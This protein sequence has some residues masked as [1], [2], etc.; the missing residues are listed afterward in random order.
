MQAIKN[1]ARECMSHETDENFR[2]RAL[3]EKLNYLL[4]ST[5]IVIYMHKIYDYEGMKLWTLTEVHSLQS[6]ENRSYVAVIKEL[7]I[8]DASAQN[9]L[10]AFSFATVIIILHLIRLIF[11]RRNQKNV[12]EKLCKVL[13]TTAISSKCNCM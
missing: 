8:K 13:T 11:C 3:I 9:A 12:E 7:S 10:S 6:I 1:S 5:S 4:K 2:G